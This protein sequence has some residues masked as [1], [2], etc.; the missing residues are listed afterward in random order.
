MRQFRID[1]AGGEVEVDFTS[2]LPAFI[3]CAFAIWKD[4]VV[5]AHHKLGPA[6]PAGVADFKFSGALAIPAI[7][8]CQFN[9]IAGPELVGEELAL[10]VVVRQGGHEE[11]YALGAVALLAATSGGQTVAGIQKTVSIGLEP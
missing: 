5:A 8:V 9:C 1:P 11:T 2:N 4:G 7:L 6:T 10:R 3:M